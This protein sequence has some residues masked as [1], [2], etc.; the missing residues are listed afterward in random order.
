M[1]DAPYDEK[2][3]LEGIELTTKYSENKEDDFVLVPS[4][5]PKTPESV[6][7]AEGISTGWEEIISEK[8]KAS[9]SSVSDSQEFGPEMVTAYTESKHAER[10]QQRRLKTDKQPDVGGRS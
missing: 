8:K 7:E 1:D 5:R 10:L 2:R 3:D 6:K 9:E 4:A